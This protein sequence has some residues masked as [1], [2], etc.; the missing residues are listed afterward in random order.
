M[1][2]ICEVVLIS[3]AI[4]VTGIFDFQ[5][6]SRNEWFITLKKSFFFKYN[7][8]ICAYVKSENDIDRCCTVGLYSICKKRNNI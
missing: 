4:I 2:L 6:N 3:N 1:I 8:C 7:H 5:C